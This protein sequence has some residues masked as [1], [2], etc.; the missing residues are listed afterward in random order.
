MLKLTDEQF[1]ISTEKESKTGP[2]VFLCDFPGLVQ[3]V[4]CACDDPRR[5]IKDMNKIYSE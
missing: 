1:E 2:S 4:F 5:H 3:I